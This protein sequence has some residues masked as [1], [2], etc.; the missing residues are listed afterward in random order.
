LVFFL[1]LTWGWALTLDP[2]EAFHLGFPWPCLYA[3]IPSFET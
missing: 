1:P 3:R 2:F